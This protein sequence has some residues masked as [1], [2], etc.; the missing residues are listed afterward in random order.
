MS[1]F[2]FKHFEIIQERSSMKVGTDGVLLGSWV[3]CQKSKNI[4]D[5]GCG[6]GLISLMLAQRN[7]KCNIIGVEIDQISSQEAKLNVKYSN[8]RKR[9]QIIN[10]SLQDFRT[11]MKF[12]LIVSNPPFFTPNNSTR[13]RDIARHTNT[14]SFQELIACAANLLIEGGGLSVILPIEFELA[15]I[16]IAADYKLYCNRLC[17]VKGNPKTTI[18]RVMMEFSFSKDSYKEELLI[19]EKS[20]H[21]YTD[22]YISLCKDFYLK[23]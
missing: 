6:T 10:T 4:L 23:M 13:R 15:F 5:I 20:R 21:Q 7:I 16:E 3:S 9:I 8:W 11:N 2:K 19:I 17:Y 12:D 18:K 22:Q 1:I 14:L